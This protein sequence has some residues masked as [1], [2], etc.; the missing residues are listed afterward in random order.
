MSEETLAHAIDPF[1]TTKPPGEGTGP[2]LSMAYG[3]FQ[4]HGGSLELQSTEGEGTRAIV[5]LPATEKV[6]AEV[7]EADP[8]PESTGPQATQPKSILVVDDDEVVRTLLCRTLEL[9][10]YDVLTA[11]NGAEGLQLFRSTDRVIDLVLLD[12]RMPVMDGY[13]A[14]RQLRTVRPDQPILLCSGYA[15]DE[16]LKSL[17]K[18][19]NCNFIRKPFA[20]EGL[21]LAVRELLG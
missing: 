8:Q 3:T 21:I 2:G 12:M 1:F 18:S 5:L 4:K 14:F 11:E 16:L 6:A 20:P 17:L 13:Q 9:A 10:G 15:Q 19:Q 7:R